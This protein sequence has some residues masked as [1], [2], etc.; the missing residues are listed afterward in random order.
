MVIV[1]LIGVY[2]NFIGVKKSSIG[3]ENYLTQETSQK[4]EIKSPLRWVEENRDD[5]TPFQALPEIEKI[6]DLVN[7]IQLHPQD[8][9]SSSIAP[10]PA[11]NTTDASLAGDYYKNFL[12]AALKANFTN[13]ELTSIKKDGEGVLLLEEL[14]ELAASGENLENLKTSFS[15]WHQ[16]DERMISELNK[17]SVKS[18]AASLHQPMVN[19]F[20]Y[21][22]ETAKKLS[23]ENFSAGQ[24][25]QLIEEFKN[26]AEA[27]NSEFARSLIALKKSP[28]FVLIPAA[29]AFTCGAFMGPFY[30]FGGRVAYIVPPTCYWGVLVTI[31]PPCGGVFLFNWAVLA[32]NP[33]LWK[34]P[35]IGS[36][37][38]GRSTV[39][40]GAC[41][42]NWCPPYGQPCA[43]IPYEAIV[44][45]FGTSLTP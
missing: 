40:P 28:D 32:A 21:H 31:S 44:L 43:Y 35:T 19:W 36:A 34:K 3:N 23:E 17:I 2:L 22:S 38:L 41:P 30:H 26:R 33:Y 10:V 15:A 18:G 20:R 16:L 12:D 9:A 29:E 4:L 27:H 39:S 42:W 11:K 24:I 25:S 7:S 1:G 45:Y 8:K 13:E 6:Q 37:V 14:M 5:Q